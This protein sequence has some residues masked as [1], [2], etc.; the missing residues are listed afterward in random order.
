MQYFDFS[1]LINKYK[2]DF[3]AVTLTDGHFDDKGEWV[4]N[5]EHR[6]TLSGAIISFRESKVFRS[7]G[8]LTS[9]DKRL[10][11]LNPIDLALQGSKVIYE[12]RL[13]SIENCTENVKFTG[14]YSY[15][16]RF[17]SAFKED[18]E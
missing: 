9:N 7:E 4:E 13:Y 10:F 8:T 17:I 16:L 5:T 2:S 6:V 18:N 15:T 14:V 12:N 3:I 1:R 11:T